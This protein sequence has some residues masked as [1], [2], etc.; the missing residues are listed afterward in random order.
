[1]LRPVVLRAVGRDGRLEPTGLGADD[2]RRRREHRRR[3]RT[4]VGRDLCPSHQAAAIADFDGAA[5]V[6]EQ[7]HSAAGGRVM[8]LSLELEATVVTEFARQRG[9]APR[10]EGEGQD[11]ARS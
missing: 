10:Q 9:E 6:L 11:S 4:Q 2:D 1:M 5:L 8:A 7:L 3:R